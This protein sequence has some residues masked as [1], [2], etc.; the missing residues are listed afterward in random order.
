MVR[1]GHARLALLLVSLACALVGRA[2]WELRAEESLLPWLWPFMFLGGAIAA[3]ALA[4][5]LRCRVAL[6]AGSL[7][8]TLAFASRACAVVANANTGT[9]P[10]SGWRVALGVCVYSLLAYI[11]MIFWLR[12]MHP[13]VSWAQQHGVR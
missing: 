7:L 4:C 3:F 13:V 12:I 9:V 8:T 5:D 2:L 10:A 11:L 1:T 6:V